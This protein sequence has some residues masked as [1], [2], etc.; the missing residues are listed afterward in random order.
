MASN[1]DAMEAEV[2]LTKGVGLIEAV[3]LFA[4]SLKYRSD[5]A[6]ISFDEATHGLWAADH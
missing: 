2:R 3:G 6:S 1:D 4:K 5:V